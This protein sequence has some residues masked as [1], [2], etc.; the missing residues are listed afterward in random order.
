MPVCTFQR[1]TTLWDMGCRSIRKGAALPD[2]SR[3]A[4][5]KREQSCPQ[6][7]GQVKG[8]AAFA[9]PGGMNELEPVS[10]PTARVRQ[11]RFR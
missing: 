7:K 10:G 9:W 2:T 5:P 1:V 11:P 6:A 8:R 4:S 3:E